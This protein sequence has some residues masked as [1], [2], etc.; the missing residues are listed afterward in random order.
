MKSL[1]DTH[2]LVFVLQTQSGALQNRRSVLVDNIV[3]KYCEV[4]RKQNHM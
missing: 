4:F 3:N 1:A 2:I